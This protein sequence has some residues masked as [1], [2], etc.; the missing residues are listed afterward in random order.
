MALQADW[1]RDSM[2]ETVGRTFSHAA[3]RS[4][5]KLEMTLAAE[6]WLLQRWL[7]AL[8]QILHIEAKFA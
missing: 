5:V 4:L 8:L 6:F 3:R 2:Q 7:K 1:L